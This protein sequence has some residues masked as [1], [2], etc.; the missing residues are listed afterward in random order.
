MNIVNTWQEFITQKEKSSILMID[1]SSLWILC[2]FF[3]LELIRKQSLE[4]HIRRSYK[5]EEMGYRNSFQKLSGYMKYIFHEYSYPD[6]VLVGLGPGSFTGVRIAVS[7]ARTISQLLKIPV[8]GIDSL[9]LYAYSIFKQ[10]KLEQFYI[11]FDAK[12]NKYFM[13]LFD[14]N[15]LKNPILD[16][17]IEHL[18]MILRH[19]DLY[20][21]HFN[22]ILQK[23]HLRD[24]LHK[25]KPIEKIDTAGWLELL[26]D[27]IFHEV[28]HLF[29]KTHYSEILP[30]YIRT[31]P[32]HEKF[33]EGLKQK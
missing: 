15:F 16:S 23:S 24:Y 5:I 30:I 6:L 19:D 17:H 4:Y 1:T 29:F 3:E 8:I 26:F 21:D 7:S 22:L 18:E 27:P 10:S 33:P 28:S 12:Q 14:K 2:S 32:A 31:D 9:S 11:G 20:L 13:K 25:I